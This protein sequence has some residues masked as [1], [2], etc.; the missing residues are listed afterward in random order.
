MNSILF[1]C[2]EYIPFLPNSH[3]RPSGPVDPPLL[4]E[5]APSEWWGDQAN[6]LFSASSNITA[7]LSELRRE[8]APLFT[9]FAGFCAF[10][11]ATMNTYV[12]S[13]PQMNLG[14]S[15]G[16]GADFD[17]DLRYLDEFRTRWSM[18]A[19]WWATIQRIRDLYQRESSDRSRYDGKTRSNFM[20]F[21][22]SVHDFTGASPVLSGGSD[23]VGYREISR[24]NHLISD[25]DQ[26]SE[27]LQQF[28]SVQGLN[29]ASH[30]AS[31]NIPDWNE[32]WALW[33]DPELTESDVRDSS[34]DYSFF[35]PHG[36][37]TAG[38]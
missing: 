3:S 34:Y 4:E 38:L 9:P 17:S 16:R 33:G 36:D 23:I 6:E 7:I 28:S 19:G 13:F 12:A 25:D 8:G 15:E 26:A 11:A 22:T 35:S 27:S 37:M 1:L 24:P 20:E 5:Q 2:R 31:Q 30:D 29:G 10:S 14:R 32:L 21:E 18:G